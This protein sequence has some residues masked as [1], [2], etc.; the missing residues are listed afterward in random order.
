MYSFTEKEMS[1]IMSENK[2]LH[3]EIETL[4][5]DFK[6]KTEEV[7]DFK[8]MLKNSREA[9]NYVNDLSIERS[10]KITDLEKELQKQ[11][12]EMKKLKN[13]LHGIFCSIRE[14]SEDGIDNTESFENN[15]EYFPLPNDVKYDYDSEGEILWD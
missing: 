6:Y 1:D 11:K 7:E 14:K 9:Y 5:N 4:K 12:Q 10:R 13:K 15:I 8:I 3:T 2:R